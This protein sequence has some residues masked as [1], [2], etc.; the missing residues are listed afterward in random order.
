MLKL[1]ELAGQEHVIVWASER[2]LG[3]YGAYYKLGLEGVGTEG[4]DEVIVPAS[5]TGIKSLVG[6]LRD[7]NAPRKVRFVAQEGT[8]YVVAVESVT[9]PGIQGVL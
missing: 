3:A 9:A 2:L 6:M 4:Y 7:S 1:N 8:N 5:L